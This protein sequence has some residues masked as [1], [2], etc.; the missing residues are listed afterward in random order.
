MKYEEFAEIDF[1]ED[2]INFPLSR[3]NFL[4]KAGSGIF[5][6]FMVGEAP[7]FA[8][9]EN[10]RRRPGIPT[11]FNAF[12]RI[13]DDGKVYCYTG[14]IEMGQGVITSLGQMLAEELDIALG[15]VEMV[16][17]DTDLCPWDIGT[18]GSLSTRHFGP[19][20][21]QAGAEGRYVLLHLASEKLGI[22]VKRLVVNN[23]IVYD[24]KSK[25]RSISYAELAKGKKIA[26]QA[27]GKVP[28]KTPDQFK[29]IGKSVKRRD[30]REK[31]TGQ[32]KY[33]ADIR[34][35]GMLYA[36]ILRPPSHFSK[37][38]TAELSNVKKIPGIRV[39]K[40]DGLIAL[41]HEHPDV[42]Q[43]AVSMIRAKFDVKEPDLDEKTIFDHLIKS[44]PKGEKISGKGTL[45]KGKK[46]SEKI[47][48]VTFTDGYKAHAP[49]EPHAALASVEGNFAKIWPSSQTPF[50][51]KDE[52]ADA[53]AIPAKNVRIISPFVGGGFGGKSRNLQVIEAAKLSKIT[54]RPVQV[55]WS[56]EEEFFFDSFR[57]A[58][59][60]KIVS[61]VDRKG[62]MTLW[63]YDVYF[64]GARG[65]QHFYDIPNSLTK[66][67]GYRRGEKSP[68]PFATG[69]WRA[70]ANNTNTFARESQIDMMASYAK[71]DPVEY[72]L[73]HLSDKKM[74]G[75]L[76]KAAE[77]FGWKKA[78]SPSGR[79]FGVALGID[80]GTFVAT[81]AEVEVDRKTGHI[82]V[83]RIVCAQNMGLVVNPRGAKLQMESCITMGMGYVLSEDLKFSGGR[84]LDKN[85]DT[86]E[87]P[88]F[89]WLPKI[90][91]Y[92]IEAQH[93]KPHGGGEPAI[94]TMGGAIANAVFDA[95]GVR[96]THMPL[97][98][99]RLKK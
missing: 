4:K 63:D 29:I 6:L 75:V 98:P 66:T 72:R 50:R 57:P 40:Q 36:K 91:S 30:S 85:F 49:I 94:V 31:V 55:A 24:K 83:K 52:V 11:D 9:E 56:R 15:S 33:A 58:A 35:P 73:N 28:V 20:L 2:P 10:R 68:H 90:E 97:D 5:I 13:A 59:V 61:G 87:I 54:K 71:V 60:V 46:S 82:Q 80:A 8:A 69:A 23:G 47:F 92:I 64:A 17:G 51:A 42:A 26:R 65:S 1:S 7:G 96:L 93:E 27:T 89:S 84:I 22:P 99:E 88:R 67:Y 78:L 43:K 19:H 12:L 32:A 74:Y 95:T 34:L 77:K 45:E 25:K 18:F 41:L 44:A 70:P 48:E 86:Y 16:M 53:L 76:K 3:R 39:I 38:I 21:R 37:L 14:K 62:R 81:I 79:G